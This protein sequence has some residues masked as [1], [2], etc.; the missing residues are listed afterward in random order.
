[1]KKNDVLQLLTGTGGDY[2]DP[3]KRPAE[4]VM[5]DVKNEYYSV[6]EAKELFGVEVDPNTFEYKELNSRS[7]G[8]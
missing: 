2:G 6:E 7:K 3:L 5:K 8:M 4:T 1:M